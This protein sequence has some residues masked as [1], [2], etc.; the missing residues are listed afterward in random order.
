MFQPDYCSLR[1]WQFAGRVHA[2]KDHCA[3]K[4]MG[5]SDFNWGTNWALASALRTGKEDKSAT[6]RTNQHTRYGAWGRARSALGVL[7]YHL[8]GGREQGQSFSRTSEIQKHEIKKKKKKQH[9]HK[10][11]VF[12]SCFGIWGVIYQH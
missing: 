3:C 11:M 2:Q 1:Q 4:G 10:E 6:G 12:C 5:T 9:T 7:V 8:G